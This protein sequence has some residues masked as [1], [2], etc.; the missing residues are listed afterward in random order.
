MEYLALYT[1]RMALGPT[2]VKN[3]KWYLDED[4]DFPGLFVEKTPEMG[5]GVFTTYALQ[6]DQYVCEYVGEL[7][8]RSTAHSR[9]TQYGDQNNWYMFWFD[10]KCIDAM[11]PSEAQQKRLGRQM[12]HAA[13]NTKEANVKPIR[14]GDRIY[15]IAKRNIKAGEQLRWD[16]GD[17]SEGAKHHFGWLDVTQ[18]DDRI[19]T[20]TF[21]KCNDPDWIKYDENCTQEFTIVD[22]MKYPN[23]EP[24]LE[25]TG[26]RCHP[27]KRNRSTNVCLNGCGSECKHRK[28]NKECPIAPGPD[29]DCGNQASQRKK[30]PK[31]EVKK[32]NIA[33]FGLF[34][35]Q[36]IPANCYLGEYTGDI[37]KKSQTTPENHY[38]YF[39][40]EINDADWWVVD[41]STNGC[42]TRFIN[43]PKGSEYHVNAVT[44]IWQ[45][46]IHP[47]VLVYSSKYIARGEEI[48]LD[49]KWTDDL[50]KQR[51]GENPP[52]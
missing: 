5:N 19:D 43:D 30:V 46:G 12:N 35:E 47:H 25:A 22:E 32:S 15:F 13:D 41:A 45:I 49:Y 24:K 21:K 36:D 44:D 3:P 7:I 16:Y 26:T 33:G 18:I 11:N 38:V 48:F 17:R 2:D 51:F 37:V 42:Y 34:A 23:N 52:S 6:K 8:S 28:E 14:S 50:Y 29:Y 40:C 20:T 10:G 31:M 1:R 4:I 39:L 9:E 27:S